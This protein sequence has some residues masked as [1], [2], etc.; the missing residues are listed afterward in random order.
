MSSREYE[1]IKEDLTVVMLSKKQSDYY[2]MTIPKVP[3]GDMALAYEIVRDGAARHIVTT[4]DLYRFDVTAT[5]LHRDAF[6][7]AQ[8]RNPVMVRTIEDMLGLP[9]R[10]Y[11]MAPT[12]YVVT[13]EQNERGAAAILY[14]GMMEYL[15]EKCGGDYAILPSSIHEMMVVT[16]EGADLHRLESLLQEVNGREVSPAERLSDRLYCYDADVGMVMR[17]SVYE[18]LQQRD[19]MLREKAAA[20]GGDRGSVLQDLQRKAP[21]RDP[22]RSEMAHGAKPRS[23]E[24]SL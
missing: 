3:M 7:S 2:G 24:E 10:K 23:R 12:M 13:N 1:A 19:A 22:A 14:P 20:Y 18:Q 15:A 4:G 21:G 16:T 17:A 11:S 8:Q 5:E 6:E 9:P